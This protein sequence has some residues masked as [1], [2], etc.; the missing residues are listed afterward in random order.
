MESISQ[1]QLDKRLPVYLDLRTTSNKDSIEKVIAKALANR[2]F[3][4][5]NKEELDK[6]IKKEYERRMNTRSSNSSL[7]QGSNVAQILVVELFAEQ[8][9]NPSTVIDSLVWTI[10]PV[11]TP[12]QKIQKQVLNS[13]KAINELIPLFIASLIPEEKVK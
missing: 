12:K 6:L 7:S 9:Q 10:T 11:P 1:Q 5:V 13:P 2:K 3:K 8:T 4:L